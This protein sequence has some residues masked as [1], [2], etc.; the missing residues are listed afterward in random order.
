MK[1]P[2]VSMQTKHSAGIG[3]GAPQTGPADSVALE[4]NSSAA[5][6]L[7]EVISTLA[8]TNLPVLVIGEPGTGK[9]ALAFAIHG[10]SRIADLPFTVITCRDAVAEQFDPMSGQWGKSSLSRP[11]T[12]LLSRLNDMSQASQSALA[13]LLA[14]AARPCVARIL[15]SSEIEIDTGTRKTW[16]REDLT[17]LLG[18]VV[19]RIPPLRHR[20]E[21]IVTLAENMVERFSTASSR[22]IAPMDAPMRKAL[23]GHAWPGN[24]PELEVAAKVIALLG[25]RESLAFIQNLHKARQKDD[26]TIP[27]KEAARAASQ[28]AE[29]EVIQKV[30]FR[31]GGNRKRAALQLEISYKA[32]LYKIKQ[33]GLSRISDRGAL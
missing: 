16:L 23:E 20:H 33:F 25:E 29:R 27:L 24:I 9:E 15:A 5:K 2:E 18:Q 4:G 26:A 22:P 10:K 19:V 6:Q 8:A 13:R 3:F 31:N 11:G 32:L 21:D 14:D 17:R 1:L 28:A 7:R 30:L 12:V